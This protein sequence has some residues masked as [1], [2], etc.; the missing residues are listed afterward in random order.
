MKILCTGNP[1]HTEK[2]TIAAG[3]KEIFTNVDFACR[4]TDYNL[5]FSDNEQL[6]Y[7]RKNI[8][9]YDVFLNC[10]SVNQYWLLQEA[11]A[12]FD[13]YGK[14]CK[15]VNIGS[16]IEFEGVF[17]QHHEYRLEKNRLRDLSLFL[18][19]PKFQSTHLI[20]FG[21]NDGVKHPNGLTVLQI[22]K[23]IKWILDQEI[24]VPILCIRAD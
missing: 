6:E 3:V 11:K 1:D 16:S 7:F 24:Q 22:A 2:K 21:I 4:N 14:P 15:V 5:E 12:S 8:C 13:T 23:T 10:S 17:N 9:N 18:T 20:C 19:E